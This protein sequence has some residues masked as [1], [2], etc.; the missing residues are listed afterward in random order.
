MIKLYRKLFDILRRED[1][2]HCSW[3]SN[4]LLNEFLNGNGDLDLFVDLEQKANF[5]AAVRQLGFIEV[6]SFVSNFPYVTHYIGFDSESRKLA[7]IHVYYKFVTGE[8]NSKNYILPL[9]NLIKKHNASVR[10]ITVPITELQKFIY[11]LR[12]FIKIGS[13]FGLFWSLGI[14]KIPRRVDKSWGDMHQCERD[15]SGNYS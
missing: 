7:H 4:N 13:T 1:I 11:L 9:E 14:E 5:E 12:F 10:R 6:S 15:I 3:K 8:S 2:F